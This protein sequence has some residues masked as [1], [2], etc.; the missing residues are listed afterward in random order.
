MAGMHPGVHH[1]TDERHLRAFR[2][3]AWAFELVDH[4]T[5][6]TVAAV[7][8]LGTVV[9]AGMTLVLGGTHRADGEGLTLLALLAVVCLVTALASAASEL[10]AWAM[11]R[12]VG[13]AEARAATALETAGALTHRLTR[14]VD[15]TD[16]QLTEP[17]RRVDLAITHLQHRLDEVDRAL[18]AMAALPDPSTRISRLELVRAEARGIATAADGLDGAT[19][20]LRWIEAC[21]W[22]PTRPEALARLKADLEAVER[23]IS[24][25][26]AAG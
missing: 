26:T 19:H 7:L 15:T 21:P 17:A 10:L 13:R 14:I 3:V 22:S 4:E 5:A 18:V 6:P 1:P 2:H 9:L 16:A 12:P 8:G 25:P 23:L 20:L 11:A 24:D